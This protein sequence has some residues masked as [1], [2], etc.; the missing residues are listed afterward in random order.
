MKIAWKIF[1]VAYFIVL[2]TVGIGGLIFVKVTAAS[3]IDSRIETVLTSNEYAGKMFFALAEKSS[4]GTLNISEIQVQVA[5]MVNTVPTDQL[6]IVGVAEGVAYEGSPFADRLSASQQGYAFLTEDASD[7]FQAVCRIDLLGGRYYVETVSD[8]SDVFAQCDQ[9]FGFYRYGVLVIA[10]LSGVVLFV[11]SRYIAFPLKRLSLTANQVAS[12]NYEKRIPMNKHGMGSEEVFRLSEDF[13]TMADAVEHRVAELKNEVEKREHFVADFTHELKTPMTSIIGYADM[14]RSYDLDEEEQ[15]EA[16]DAIYREG[17]RLE[18]LSMRLLDIIV[19][20]N[21]SPALIPVHVEPLFEAIRQSLQF[22][23]KKYRIRLQL[24]AEPAVVSAE[25]VLLQSLLYNLIDNACKA[26]PADETVTVRG[27][28]IEEGYLITVIDHGRGI[29]KESLQK[30]TE[31]FYMEDKSRTR[32]QGGA[33]LGLA[34]C[35]RI[36]EL[37]GT[38]L[39]FSSTLGQGTS[40]AF[41]FARGK[42]E[43]DGAGEEGLQ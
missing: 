15:R 38:S 4:P 21:E 23:L 1:F 9:L 25:P 39:T 17:R 22:L 16:A 34:L 20:G 35:K 7:K 31:P 13:N 6:N 41:T 18:R 3:M 11:F 43:A 37:H 5:K 26:S 33:G 14:L 40:V 8:F 29:P 24:Y 32:G 12:G 27:R 10:L 36:A 28:N 30:I 42:R 19:L 2:L